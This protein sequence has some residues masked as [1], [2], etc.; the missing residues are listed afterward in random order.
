MYRYILSL[1]LIPP[2]FSSEEGK[3]R[4]TPLLVKSPRSLDVAGL[5][6]GMVA[7]DATPP[8]AK[9]KAACKPSKKRT[10]RHR[11]SYSEL[12]TPPSSPLSSGSELEEE[13]RNLYEGI[14]EARRRDLLLRELHASLYDTPKNEK[15]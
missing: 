2:M 14:V 4:P 12:N 1:M 15:E 3:I 5:G 6:A 11:R 7:L 8:V 9:P 13:V 10:S